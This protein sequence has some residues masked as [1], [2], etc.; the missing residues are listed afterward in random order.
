MASKHFIS[1]KR[2][3]VL[4]TIFHYWIVERQTVIHHVESQM[5][6]GQTSAVL[7]E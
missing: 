3:L 6:M 7:D 1:R 4:Q 2:N 5:T